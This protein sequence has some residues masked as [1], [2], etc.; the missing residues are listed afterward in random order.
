M[1]PLAA[2]WQLMDDATDRLLATAGGLSDT[3]CRAPSLLPD[4]SRGHLLTHLAR[5]ADALGGLLAAARSGQD[6]QMYASAESRDADI[7]AGANRP[8]AELIADVRESAGRLRAAGRSLEGT[9][10]WDTVQEWRRGRRRPASDVP[11]ARLTEVELHHVD[12]GAG[13]TLA[14]TPPEVGDALIAESLARLA[15]VADTPAFWV[16]VDGEEVRGGADGGQDAPGAL[17]VVGTRLELVGWLSGRTDGSG[18]RCDG[19]LPR[20]PAWG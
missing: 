2:M 8:A 15:T 17:T 16:R 6:A 4:W 10:G 14:D 7:E 13:H 12:L 5:N 9:P 18:L 3:E 1:T 20:L 11:Q 19:A